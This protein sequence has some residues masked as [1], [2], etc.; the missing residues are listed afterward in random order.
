MLQ[1][2]ENG[3]M[4][5]KT[6]SKEQDAIIKTW[7]LMKKDTKRGYWYGLVSKQL[8]LNLQQNG[9]LIA[10]AKKL[11]NKMQA[12]QDAVDAERVK[13]DEDVIPMCRFPVK[14]NLYKHQIRAA[15]MALITFGAV[16]VGHTYV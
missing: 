13:P 5:V 11:L 16:E 4:F 2:I 9:G 8:L 6:D 7:R 15:N 14:A 12:V 1:K 3:M 10:P